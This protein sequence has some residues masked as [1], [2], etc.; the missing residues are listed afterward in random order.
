MCVVALG[1][2]SDFRLIVSDDLQP[3]QYLVGWFGGIVRM[4]IAKTWER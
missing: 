1:V 4:L 3:N 2:D